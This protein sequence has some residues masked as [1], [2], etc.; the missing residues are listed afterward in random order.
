MDILASALSNVI[1]KKTTIFLHHGKIP[2][3]CM[4]YK[5]SRKI[6]VMGKPGEKLKSVSECLQYGRKV[7]RQYARII[8]KIL[9]DCG[10]LLNV[11]LHTVT[12]TYNFGY[13]IKYDDIIEVVKGVYE[14]EIFPAFMIKRLHLH[15]NLFASGLMVIVG[16]KDDTDVQNL[17]KP[18]IFEIDLCQ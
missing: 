6:L 9:D 8:Q 18:L 15:I 4:I 16:L 17:V 13:Q 12:A 10:Q 14:P 5:K 2:L 3:S 7:L 11:K 1:K